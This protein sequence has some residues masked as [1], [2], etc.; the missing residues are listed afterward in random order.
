MSSI[1]YSLNTSN[2]ATFLYNGIRALKSTAVM[3]WVPGN[4]LNSGNGRY[5]MF[6]KGSQL[7]H[8]RMRCL[9]SS[10][11]LQAIDYDAKMAQL[12]DQKAREQKQR[13][14]DDSKRRREVNR[15]W[16]GAVEYP[17]ENPQR[18]RRERVSEIDRWHE[19][20]PLPV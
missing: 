9:S 4:V 12:Q 16:R 20:S 14:E 2:E 18:T 15:W 13:M 7:K 6:I 3:F 8:C 11:N 5:S 10:S 1:P 19:T 17:I